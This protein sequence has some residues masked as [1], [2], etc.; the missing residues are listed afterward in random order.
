MFKKIASLVLIFTLFCSLAGAPAFA[1][2]PSVTGYK[3]DKVNDPPASGTPKEAE[4]G[5]SLRA[6]ITKLVADARAGKRLTVSDPQNQPRQSNGLSKGTKIAIVAGIGT[7][8][9][10]AILF[11]HVR[12]H[13]FDGFT[14]GNR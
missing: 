11:F 4:A 12:R 2:V 14:L 3:L 9:I 6:E 10:L 7:A 1:R 8:I 5:E 13:L